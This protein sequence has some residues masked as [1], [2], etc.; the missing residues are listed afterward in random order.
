[1]FCHKF[2]V[3]CPHCQH[4]NLPDNS[5]KKA[6][7]AVLLCQVGPCRKCGGSLGSIGLKETAT[8]KQIREQLEAEGLLRK[9]QPLPPPSQ[10]TVQEANER[11]FYRAMEEEMGPGFARIFT[12]HPELFLGTWQKPVK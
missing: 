5:Y 3:I 7:R 2:Y 1:M 4:R 11:E 12:D 6:I 8:V 10:Q 9:P